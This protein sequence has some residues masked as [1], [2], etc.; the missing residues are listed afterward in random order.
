MVNLEVRG[1]LLA[2]LEFPNRD[3][4]REMEWPGLLVLL[5]TCEPMV[6]ESEIARHVC[7]M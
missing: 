4:E 7:T 6:A 5:L 1:V 3:S 2:E